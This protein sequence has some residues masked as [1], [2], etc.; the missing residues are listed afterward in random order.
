MVFGHVSIHE[1]TLE[2]HVLRGWTTCSN[3][4]TA[5]DSIVNTIAT[6]SCMHVL[7][8]TF[9]FSSSSCSCPYSI[10][11]VYIFKFVWR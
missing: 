10:N 11:H 7:F 5:F 2:L 3:M 9:F 6:T 4:L 1:W 8:G